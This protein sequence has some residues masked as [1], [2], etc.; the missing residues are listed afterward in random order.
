[1]CHDYEMV[2]KLWH[3]YKFLRHPIK[4]V[5]SVFCRVIDSQLNHRKKHRLLVIQFKHDLHLQLQANPQRFTMISE[6]HKTNNLVT[7]WILICLPLLATTAGPVASRATDEVYEVLPQSATTT[8][9]T[10]TKSGN[11]QDEVN[12]VVTP[13][14]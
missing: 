6:R 10:A 11:R 2:I 4:F 8:T 3:L 12:V 14:E 7:I 9:T 1:M 5:A 13:G